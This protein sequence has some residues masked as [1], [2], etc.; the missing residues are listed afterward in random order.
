MTAPVRIHLRKYLL[1]LALLPLLAIQQGC[2]TVPLAATDDPA[3]ARITDPKAR[4][5]LENGDAEAAA[6]IYS[7]RAAA[8]NDPL[9]RE[10]FQL[11]AAEILFDRAML[12]PG[13]A[14]LAELPPVMSSLPLQQRR[15]IVEAKSLLYSRDAEAALNA[16]PDPLAV[17]SPLHRARVYETQ[18]QSYRFLQ[19]PDNELTARIALESQLDNQDIVDL[20]HAQIWQMLTTQPLDTL[21]SMTTNVRSDTYQ[22]WIELALAYT[23]AGL[24]GQRRSD[25][26][27]QWEQR[28]PRHPARA[29]FV[30][31]L[32]EPFDGSRLT[33]AGGVINRLA[34]LLPLSDPATAEVADA[35][36]DGMIAAWEAADQVPVL[37]FYDVGPNPG[38]ARNVYR[39]AVEDG[40]DT[41]IGPLRK[42]A[43][44]AIV[45]Q[46]A[47][48]LPTLTLNT[49]DIPT[50]NRTGSN[51]VQFGLAPEDEARAAA[52]RAVALSLNNAVI[53]QSDDA[54][55]DREARAF[56]NTLFRYGGDVVHVGVL[57]PDE[58]DYSEQIREALLITESDQ[59]FRTLS[60]NIG[61]KLFFEP[62]IRNDVDVVFLAVSNEQA[63]SVRPQLDFFHAA[64]LPRIGTSRIAS[65]VP[66]EKVDRDLNS[67]FYADAP[68]VLREALRSDPLRQD[69]IDSFPAANGV[70]ARLYALGIDAF[71]LATRLPALS[72]GGMI[73]GYTGDLTLGADGR[74]ERRLDW[75]QYQE[76]KSVGIPRIEAEPLAPVLSGTQN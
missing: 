59:R 32:R 2:T 33:S 17:S 69:I 11:L 66:D 64:Q 21:R 12:E 22:G 75:A 53:L 50:W 25:E 41:I 14:R 57:P 18:A 73:E 56:Q 74:V 61:R 40:A 58:Y 71:T 60:A 42:P 3:L 52:L 54:R 20:N 5:A 51:I 30:A 4:A 67:I 48:A 37:R 7:A 55:G 23:E 24:E 72:D 15:Q 6:D 1:L 8:S 76:G 39:E 9:Q 47:V 49:V 38:N 13:L 31:S 29:R 43:V 45:T 26:L 46:Q 10:D 63:R 36:R 68:W 28:F 16:L 44:A 65:L 19:D 62:S 70:F 27:A 35:I 34:V